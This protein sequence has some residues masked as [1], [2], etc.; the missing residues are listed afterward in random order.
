MTKTPP[1]K[2]EVPK[3]MQN[4]KLNVPQLKIPEQMSRK[5]SVQFNTTTPRFQSHSSAYARDS[6]I[7]TT[8]ME[9]N[10]DPNATILE[11]YDPSL[12]PIFEEKETH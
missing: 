10:N 1:M 11:K 3:Y 4:A 12:N 7:S 2:L 9:K 8:V 5:E 6:I